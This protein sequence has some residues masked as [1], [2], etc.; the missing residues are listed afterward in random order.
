MKYL[1]QILN[2]A[3]LIPVLAFFTVS[4]ASA[5]EESEGLYETIQNL[6][7][8]EL[9]LGVLTLG[10]L[11]VALLVL[12]AVI[13]T[14]SVVKMIV[15]E[16]RVK[17][18]LPV[19]EKSETT[20]SSWLTKVN[21]AVPVEEEE[22]IELDHDYDGIRELDNHL[23]PWWKALFWVSIV[24]GIGY[25]LVYHVFDAAP[26]QAEEYEIAV[27]EARAEAEKMANVIDESS[28][29]FTDDPAHI[30]NGK[31]VFE[32]NCAV[33]HRNDMGGQVGPN[34]TD[35]YWIHGGSAEDI[36]MTI[37]NGVPEKGMISWEDQLTKVQI[38]N[39]TSYIHSLYDTEPDNPKEPQGEVYKY[40]EE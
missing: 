12:L 33:C 1:S 39:V 28:L 32:A 16:K 3:I 18:G 21:D 4:Y 9:I 5:Q 36:Y 37:K 27:A 13:Y 19:E 8:T 24:W 29:S 34:L 26:L 10:L 15:R 6:S 11:V 38:R 20:W 7:E 22:E 30:E 40:E 31:L 25:M 23:P 17:E 2:K 14:L 35:E